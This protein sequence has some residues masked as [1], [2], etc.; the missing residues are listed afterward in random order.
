MA[1]LEVEHL[2]VSLRSPEGWVHPV[3]DVS[4]TVSRGEILSVVGESGCGKSTTALAVMGLLAENVRIAGQIRLDGTDMLQLNEA[5]MCALR[6]NRISMIFQEPMTALNPVKTIGFQIMEPLLV[7]TAITKAEA[8]EKAIDLLA[9]VG[10]DQPSRRIDAYP[11]QLSG[12]QRQRVVIAVALACEPDLIVADEPTTALDTTVQ[13]QILELLL[14]LVDETSVALMLITHNLAVVSEVA[15]RM[16]VM[17]GGR[18]AETGPTSDVLEQPLH[19]Y[20]KG[21]IAALPRADLSPGERLV[22]IPGVVPRL[23]NMPSGCALA[24]RCPQVIDA[25]RGARPVERMIR[26]AH[27]VSCIRA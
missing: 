11:H 15:D 21:L 9:R 12:G 16:M 23:A 7:H 20:T 5:Q 3:D 18:V 13:R 14:Q 1:L 22:P 26:P 25:C 10:I 2:K 8:R 24:D 17:Y 19:P 4:F 27:Q 6:G